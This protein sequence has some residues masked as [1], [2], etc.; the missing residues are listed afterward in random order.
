[1]LEKKKVTINPKTLSD[2]C[3]KFRDEVMQGLPG[4]RMHDRMSL[5]PDLDGLLYDY[6]VSHN[7]LVLHETSMGAA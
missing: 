5:I 3:G 6:V 1:M 7:L 2:W 4:N